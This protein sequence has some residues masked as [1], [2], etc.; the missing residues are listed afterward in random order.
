M[1]CYSRGTKRD[2]SRAIIGAWPTWCTCTQSGWKLSFQAKRPW[3]CCCWP[4]WHANPA[5]HQCLEA[6]ICK[7]W[8]T[9][10]G[11]LLIPLYIHSQH[12]PPPHTLEMVS[13]L[14]S[15]SYSWASSKRLL[16]LSQMFSITFHR[17]SNSV[18]QLVEWKHPGLYIYDLT[19]V[20]TLLRRQLC[21]PIR[22]LWSFFF[23]TP[24]LKPLSLWTT[25]MINYPQMKMNMMANNYSIIWHPRTFHG[26]LPSAKS[27]L[28]T[29]WGY[30]LITPLSTFGLTT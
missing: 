14:C 2:Q 12:P 4:Q 7:M 28:N 5:Q 22:G 26:V 25:S 20:Q 27:M 19:H 8:H 15:S 17:L 29:F 1:I 30:I 3:L 9:D 13:C 6:R 21:C 16:P 11:T 24:P 18:R 23:F 10:K